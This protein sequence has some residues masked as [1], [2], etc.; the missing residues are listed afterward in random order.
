[1]CS[2]FISIYKSQFYLSS[3]YFQNNLVKLLPHS[4][5][6]IL[7]ANMCGNTTYER[8][9]Y[10]MSCRI[11]Y[12]V[13]LRF[14]LAY[15]L[16]AWP[17]THC[18]LI[19]LW[20]WLFIPILPYLQNRNNNSTFLIRLLIYVRHLDQDLA[21]R[22]ITEVLDFFAIIHCSFHIFHLFSLL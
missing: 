10:S 8:N 17:Q 13:S 14:R 15:L 22:N 19:W 18:A 16:S 12:M 7:L 9:P 4:I 21:H 1:M 2:F 5:I 20:S 3:D 6:S 11:K